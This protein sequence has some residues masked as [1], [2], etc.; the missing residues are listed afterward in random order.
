MLDYDDLLFY[1]MYMMFDFVLV[2]DFGVCFD[3]VLIDEY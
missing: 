2:V 1:W 3:Y